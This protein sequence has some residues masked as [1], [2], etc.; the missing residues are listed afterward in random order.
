M[1]LRYLKTFLIGLIA[2]VSIRALFVIL[3]VISN[4]ALAWIVCSI[5]FIMFVI[6]YTLY[7]KDKKD[8]I[9]G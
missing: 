4:A 9:D 3:V 7:L 6:C 2:G 1:F 8:S 5:L